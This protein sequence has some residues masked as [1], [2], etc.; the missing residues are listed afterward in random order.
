MLNYSND[1]YLKL[2]YTPHWATVLKKAPGVRFE[3]TLPCGEQAIMV[4]SNLV[5]RCFSRIASKAFVLLLA[6]LPSSAIPASNGY[7]LFE[8]IYKDYCFILIMPEPEQLKLP[9]YV[10]VTLDFSRGAYERMQ[11]LM[12]MSG[13]NHAGVIRDSLRVLDYI[14]GQQRDGYTVRMVKDGFFFRRV[15][16]LLDIRELL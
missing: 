1:C 10:P 5:F 14:I 2:T 12:A 16:T 7:R 8:S 6:H 9:L 4:E 11:E 15:E 3:L 13:A